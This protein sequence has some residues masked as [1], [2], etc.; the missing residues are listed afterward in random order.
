[1]V[2]RTIAEEWLEASQ[3]IDEWGEVILEKTVEGVAAFQGDSREVVSLT[4][5]RRCT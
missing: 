4:I 5:T 3:M 2:F 1:M